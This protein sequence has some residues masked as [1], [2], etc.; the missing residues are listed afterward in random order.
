MIFVGTDNLA[1]RWASTPLEQYKA[2]LNEAGIVVFPV[3]GQ[4]SEVKADEI[5]YEDDY[6]G[7]ALAAIFDGGKFEIRWHRDF[8][9]VRVKSIF[10]GLLIH[11]QTAVFKRHSL[12]YQAK[13]I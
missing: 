13:I 8:S 11:P 2:T 3:S 1:E 5:S 4:H 12:T 10:A 9:E 7:N 6:K